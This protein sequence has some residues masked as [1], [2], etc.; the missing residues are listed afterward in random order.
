MG[1][2]D[3]LSSKAENEHILHE[4]ER[5]QWEMTNNPQGE[6]DEMVDIYVQRG[7]SKQDAVTAIGLM[8]KYEEFFINV[9]MAEELG[10]MVP[11]EDDNPWFGGLITC[12]SFIFFG[13]WPL[14]GYLVVPTDA[15][16]DVQF[17][18][19]IVF[20]ILMLFVLGAIKSKFS[21][22]VW[23]WSGLETVGMGTIAAGSAFFIGWFVRVV[24][25]G[26]QVSEGGCAHLLS[27]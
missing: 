14:L 13:L 24:A 1:I 17:I 3:A 18:V 5:E 8:A 7:M 23:Y 11:D 10:L 15:G 20:T 26:D 19:A 27:A 21:V 9:M 12:C 4:K 22:R 25:L 6:I 2:G 16:Q